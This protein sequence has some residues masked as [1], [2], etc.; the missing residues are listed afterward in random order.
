MSPRLH[1]PV[2]CGVFFLSGAA[3]L[4][5]ETLWF[6]QAGLAFGN[7]V[8]ASSL[9]LSSFMAGLALGAWFRLH[10]LVGVRMGFYPSG[11]IDGCRI[12]QRAIRRRVPRDKGGTP[13]I[14]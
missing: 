11:F 13:N 7:S 5:F 12:N 6:R 1:S 14:R 2:L 9:V 8:W 4:V 3:A 10:A